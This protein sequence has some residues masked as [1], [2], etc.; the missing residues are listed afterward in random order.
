LRTPHGDPDLQG[1]WNFAT[2]TPMERPGQLAGRERLTEE[3]AAE[4]EHEIRENASADRREDPARGDGSKSVSVPARSGF[5]NCGGRLHPALIRL[6]TD[7]TPGR[8]IL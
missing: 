5:K 3:E 6:K 7:P 1:V 4:F 2:A 8:T